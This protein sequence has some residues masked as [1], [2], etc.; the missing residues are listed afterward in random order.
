MKNSLHAV[1]SIIVY[2]FSVKPLQQLTSIDNLSSTNTLNNGIN[3]SDS[4]TTTNTRSMLPSTKSI[5]TKLKYFIINSFILVCINFSYRNMSKAD[6]ASLAR[7]KKK[8]ADHGKRT[9]FEEAR[10]AMGLYLESVCY[11]IQCA[12]DET[13]QDQRASLLTTTLTMLQ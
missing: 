3:I 10:E 7:K 8:Q 9:T 2:Y 5:Y 6:L 12:N 11:F 4:L 1:L 13:K